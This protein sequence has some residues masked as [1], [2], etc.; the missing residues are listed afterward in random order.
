MVGLFSSG[1]EAA[2]R[3]SLLAHEGQTRK[4]DPIPYVSHPYHVALLLARSG[5]DDET[6]Q[7]GLLHDVVEDCEEWTSARVEE[8][9]GL[10]VAAVVAEVT[11]RKG[12]SWET[13]KGEALAAVETMSLRALVVKAAD[14]LHNMRSLGARLDAASSPEEAW[15]HFSRGPAQT[16]AHARELVAAL[17]RRLDAVDGFDALSVDLDRALEGL[18]RHEP[19]GPRPR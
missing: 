4:G 12:E 6:I 5:A 13:R 14:K 10:E 17:R 3:A 2:I 8:E 19:G 16:I 1:V 7:A 11:E 9:F 18:V 15:S